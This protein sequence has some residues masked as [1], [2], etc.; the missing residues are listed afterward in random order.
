MPNPNQTRSH[1]VLEIAAGMVAASTRDFQLVS[2][3]ARSPEGSGRSHRFLSNSTAGALTAVVEGHADLAMVNPAAALAAAYHGKGPFT[4]CQPLRTIA[5]IPSRDQF[6]FAVR[7]ETRLTSFEDIGRRQYPLRVSVRGN[8]DHCIHFMLRDIADAAGFAFADLE[9]WGGE[10]RREGMTPV[11]SGSKFRALVNGDI[12]AIFDEAA[13][14]WLAAAVDAGM[15]ILPL[16]ETTVLALEA[17]GYRRATLEKANFPALREDVLTI[18]FS[19][20]P[21]FVHAEA[22][23]QMVVD[24]CTALKARKHLIPWQ[25]EGGFPVERMCREAPDTPQDVPFHPAA[26][27][28]WRDCGYMS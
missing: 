11:P 9:R 21:I 19:G 25:G 12:D 18:D 4:S 22:D 14:T 6:V 24:I 23:D 7:K 5:V 16:A 8:P 2:V 17:V 28:F 15:T 3:D 1:V 26:E 10:I 20:W 27:R 13:D